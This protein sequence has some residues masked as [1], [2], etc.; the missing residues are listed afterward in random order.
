MRACQVMYEMMVLGFW[1]LVAARRPRPH[2]RSVRCKPGRAPRRRRAAPR[3]R[4]PCSCPAASTPT[5]ACSRWS[6]SSRAWPRCRRAASAPR[7]RGHRAQVVWGSFVQS[8]NCKA[9]QVS[10]LQRVPLKLIKCG[11]FML[12]EQQT[13]V[14]ALQARQLLERH[15]LSCRASVEELPRDKLAHYGLAH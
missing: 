11:L 3:W 5:T 8:L 6:I 12:A 1:G 4:A 9:K 13:G 15:L 14:A 10:M 2:C 7:D